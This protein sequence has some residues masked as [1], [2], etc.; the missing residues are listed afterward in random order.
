MADGQGELERYGAAAQAMYDNLERLQE[1]YKPPGEVRALLA[2]EQEFLSF[3]QEIREAALEY[4][5]GLQLHKAAPEPESFDSPPQFVIVGLDGG[6]VIFSQHVTDA[7]MVRRVEG[8][9]RV[10]IGPGPNATVARLPRY[11]IALGVKLEQFEQH[12]GDDYP[13]ALATISAE[14]RRREASARKQWQPPAIG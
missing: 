8:F 7:Q 12:L 11:V 13:S 4:A 10:P 14:W 5:R 1:S 6:R 2:Q 3:P 9:D